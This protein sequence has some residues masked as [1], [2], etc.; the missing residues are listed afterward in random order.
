MNIEKLQIPAW[1]FSTAILLFVL[2][3][4]FSFWTGRKLTWN[5]F[6]W[7]PP[8]SLST[9]GN[10]GAA[11]SPGEWTSLETP[12][13]WE[14]I[15]A[16]CRVHNGW[17][18]FRGTLRHPTI[19]ADWPTAQLL[20]LPKECRPRTARFTEMPCHGA[21]APRNL[22]C[23]NDFYPDGIVKIHTDFPITEQRFEGVRVWQ[24]E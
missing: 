19:P 17:V 13:G 12:A 16:K 8:P 6:G 23:N 20:I 14:N 10:L 1:V 3:L 9:T 15:D 5:P 4:G 2:L 18:E 7:D 11:L 21:T 24:G 22:V